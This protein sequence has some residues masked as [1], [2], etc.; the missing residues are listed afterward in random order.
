VLDKCKRSSLQLMY[1]QRADA[2]NLDALA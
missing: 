2:E 1:E